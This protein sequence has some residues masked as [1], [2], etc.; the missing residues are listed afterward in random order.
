[1]LHAKQALKRKRR[2]KA[3]PVLGAA[4]LCHW[5]AAQSHKRPA[6]PQICARGPSNRVT[7]S[8]SMR[9]KFSTSAWRRSTSSTGKTLPASSLS[10]AAAAAAA[11]DAAAAA[12]DAA[13]AMQWVAAV[14]STQWVAVVADALEAAAVAAVADADVAASGGGA[15]AA[16]YRGARASSARPHGSAVTANGR[17]T[18]FWATHPRRALRYIRP[19]RCRGT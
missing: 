9:K 1:M 14:A 3:V 12:V 2:S 17:P 11:T 5:R 8:P 7:N 15:A 13:A 10:E 16:V 6:P 4:G 19:A 18:P